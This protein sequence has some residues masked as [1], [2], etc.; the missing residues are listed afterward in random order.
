[1]SATDYRQSAAER[2][3]E[4]PELL[5]SLTVRIL[6]IDQCPA[7]TVLYAL[8]TLLGKLMAGGHVDT[9]VCS[10]LDRR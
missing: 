10:D 8:K 2:S 4:S 1:M 9:S 6:S 7:A 5:Q 3:K